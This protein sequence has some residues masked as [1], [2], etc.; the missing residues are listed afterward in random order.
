[1]AES[2]PNRPPRRRL[3]VPPA[4]FTSSPD[5]TAR[6]SFPWLAESE[7]VV[8][9]SRVVVVVW[10]TDTTGHVDVEAARN[11]GARVTTWDMTPT[12]IA[13]LSR[14][15]SAGWNFERYDL[16]VSGGPDVP[17]LLPAVWSLRAS[18][19]APR[20]SQAELDRLVE[21]EAA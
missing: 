16:L 4:P 15:V 9:G 6:L 19:H 18:E 5:V 20:V 11:G 21:V 8:Y 2:R 3:S 14:L 10:P 7:P 17:R 13:A 12:E 1:V